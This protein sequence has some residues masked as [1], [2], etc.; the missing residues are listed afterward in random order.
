MSEFDAIDILAA[1]RRVLLSLTT[2]QLIRIYR[3]ASELLN[4]PT[5]EQRRHAHT[6]RGWIHA[7]IAERGHLT[8]LAAAENVCADHWLPVQVCADC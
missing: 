6:V 2:D 5:E 7:E 4:H 1:A 3:R 8:R